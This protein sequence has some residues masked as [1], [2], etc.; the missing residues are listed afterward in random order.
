[1]TAAVMVAVG[2][3]CI[4]GVVALME[5]TRRQDHRDANLRAWRVVDDA[6]RIVRE[7][8]RRMNHPSMMG[9]A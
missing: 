2:V 7:Y 8:E 1:M 9:D 3:G 4:V 5:W 6:D